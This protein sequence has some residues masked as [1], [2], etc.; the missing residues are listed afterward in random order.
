MKKNSRILVLGNN[1]P[2]GQ[3]IISELKEK[4]IAAVFHYISLHESP[5]FKEKYEGDKLINCDNYS[6]C[7]IRLPM[8]F[9]LNKV[10]QV[11][12]I[13]CVLNFYS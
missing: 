1:T 13:N 4:S 11:K 8:F 12:V 2:I 9:E 5:Y 3:S 10:A 6:N 7:I